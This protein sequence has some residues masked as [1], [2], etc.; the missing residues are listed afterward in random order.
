MF[1]KLC[2]EF[3]C[4]LHG[5]I[6]RFLLPRLQQ[7]NA[8]LAGMGDHSR[9]HVPCDEF[10]NCSL[11]HNSGTAQPNVLK[12]AVC[13]AVEYVRTLHRSGWEGGGG[14]IRMFSRARHFSVS[15]ER[16][17]TFCLNLV[18]ARVPSAKRFTQFIGRVN[19]PVRTCTPLFRIPGAAGRMVMKFDA[20]LIRG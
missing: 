9:Q 17:D 2:V 6:G 18:M 10:Q 12:V 5:M 4:D 3:P 1:L 15:W 16:V 11:S 8:H 19:Q 20:F 13:L 14:D 7:D